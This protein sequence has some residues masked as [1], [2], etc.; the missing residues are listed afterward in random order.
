VASGQL[1]GELAKRGY[2]AEVLNGDLSQDAREA[3]L[4]RFRMNQ[5]KVL[6]ATDVAARGLDIDD[7]SHVFN[8]DL[9]DDE[10]MYVHRIGRT[11]RAGKSGAAISLVNPK[12]KWLLRKIESFTRQ[13]IARANIPTEEDILIHRETQLLERMTVWL[14]RARYRRE[15]ELVQKLADDGFDP[16]EIAAAALKI[17]RK[18]EKQRPIAPVSEIQ[19]SPRRGVRSRKKGGKTSHE[20]GMVRLSISKGRAHGVRPNDVVSTIAFYADIPG[21]VIGKIRIQD[22]FT[23]V[24]VPERYAGQVLSKSGTYR[25]KKQA[26]AVELA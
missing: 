1:A 26:A 8:F 24:D 14:G 11:G 2:P 15:R 17:A 6:V 7:I 18:E 22:K 10:E 20:A 16:Y 13:K 12:Q 4:N 19:H 21:S 25:I 23:H 5:I 3:V 9:P